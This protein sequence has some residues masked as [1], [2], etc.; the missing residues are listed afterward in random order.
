MR[1]LITRPQPE[2]DET[3]AR[4]V[5]RGHD[6]M[7]GPVLHYTALPPPPPGAAPP[8]ALVFTSRNGVRAITGWPQKDAWRGV[9]VF[10][11]GS[12]TAKAAREAGFSDVR[13]GNGDG[14]ALALLI[15]VSLNVDAGTIVYPAAEDRAPALEQRLLGAGYAVD[16]VPSYRMEA[17]SALPSE[18]AG[19]LGKGAIDGILFYSNRTAATFRRL[20]RDAGLLPA[21]AKLRAYVMSDA[22]AEPLAGL[23]LEVAVAAR[24]SEGGL[25][26]IIPS[27]G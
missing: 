21:L 12:A 27:P 13:S 9:P 23:S 7:V 1:L 19:A 16:V 4:L 5:A 8:A 24:P 14:V 26:S 25:L 11:V 10:V 17:S 15:V 18:V 6:V 2:A 3:A 22:V 20:A